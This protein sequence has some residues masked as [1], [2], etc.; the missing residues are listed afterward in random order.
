MNHLTVFDKIKTP[1]P[2]KL[3]ALAFGG[4]MIIKFDG[5]LVID[6]Q[7]VCGDAAIQAHN[8][9]KTKTNRNI[10]RGSTDLGYH[11]S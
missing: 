3:V 10:V 6:V 2:L 11:T 8:I 9:T 7:Y 4:T 5:C 1:T